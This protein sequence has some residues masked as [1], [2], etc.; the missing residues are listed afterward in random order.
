VEGVEIAK[1]F[2]IWGLKFYVLLTLVCKFR[3][4]RVL[5]SWDPLHFSNFYKIS[6]QFEIIVFFPH[7]YVTID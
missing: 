3:A 5:V 7:E 6:V 4:K 2:V 1:N